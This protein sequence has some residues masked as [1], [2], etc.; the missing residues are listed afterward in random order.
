M[1][2]C[3]TLLI[4]Q[5]NNEGD[6]MIML[7][8]VLIFFLIQAGLVYGE[9]YKCRHSSGHVEFTDKPCPDKSVT[10][11]ISPTV[12]PTDQSGV[13][14][15]TNNQNK[16]MG[17]LGQRADEARARVMAAG[18]PKQMT[19][20]EIQAEQASSQGCT[21]AKRSYEIEAGS[22]KQNKESIDASK[23]FMYS[24]CGM[25]EPNS[26]NLNNT[27]NLNVHDNH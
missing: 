10:E 26:I 25:T 5:C 1:R 4:S 16:H 24:A 7:R 27:I 9:T 14:G 13:A 12:F 2:E 21:S 11:S 18:T 17:T 19:S 15:Q 3:K 20:A 22:F 8:A 23:R 6:F